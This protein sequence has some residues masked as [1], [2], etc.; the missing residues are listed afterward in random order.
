MLALSLV[1]AT[2][3]CT[4]LLAQLKRQGLGNTRARLVFWRYFG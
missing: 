4:Y 3:Y 2:K 1:Y